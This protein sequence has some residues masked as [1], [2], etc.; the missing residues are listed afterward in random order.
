MTALLIA[1]LF[2]ASLVAPAVVIAA[3]P[4]GNVIQVQQPGSGPGANDTLNIQN[5]LNACAGKGPNCTVQ[6]QAGT[7]HTSQLVAYNFRGTFKGAGQRSTTIQALKH[8]SVGWPDSG[9]ICAPNT[10]TWPMLIIFVGGTIEVSDLTISEPWTGTD[11]VTPTTAWTWTYLYDLLAFTGQSRTDASLDRVSLT[12]APDPTTSSFDYGDTSN[13]AAGQGGWNLINGVD[14]SPFNTSG[15]G[16]FWGVALTG[17]FGVRNSTVSWAYNPI[18]LDGPHAHVLVTIGGAP[19]AG[20]TL[21]NAGGDID[22]E[23]AQ[24]SI[25][26]ISYNTL[27]VTNTGMSVWYDPNEPTSP[28][29]YL[30]HDNRFA[31]QWGCGCA[32]IEL[33]DN[34]VAPYIQARIWNNTINA[35]FDNDGIWIVGTKGATITGN[36]LTSA[37]GGGEVGIA[38][39]GT[40]HTSV[41]ANNVGGFGVD[42]TYDLAQIWLSPPYPDADYYGYPLPAA[43]SNL[44]ACLNRSD[45]VMDQGTN[46][47]LVHCASVTAP[48]ALVAPLARPAPP[49]THKV[50]LKP[51]LP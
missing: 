34:P 41:I 28:S 45:Q 14:Y 35:A 20:N 42:P 29:Q 4:W 49:A 13:Y 27:A 43:S 23:S 33:Y 21:S 12:G 6:L 31:P 19:G 15:S 5:A 50:P 44:V 32:G 51:H 24:S 22:L 10:C 47:T 2:A 18:A 8:L 46:N 40:T 36:T 39:V 17:S 7:Y 38:L 11:E 48:Q 16:D 30:I 3:P 26:D 1:G 37:A 9:P 25:F